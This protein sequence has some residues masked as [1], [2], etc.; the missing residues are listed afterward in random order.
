MYKPALSDILAKA[1]EMKTV[2]ESI[3]YLLRF[4]SEYQRGYLKLMFCPSLKFHKD[5]PDGKTPYTPSKF[6]EPG[7]LPSELR[8]MYLFLDDKSNRERG[9]N[10]SV[11]PAA[12]R[13]RLWVEILESVSPNDAIFLDHMKEKKSPYKRIG[14]SLIKKAYPGLIVED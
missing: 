9:A 14:P 1:S 2:E 3:E 4:D 8:R 12:K 10:P 13:Q 11:L 6:D 7:R 5:L